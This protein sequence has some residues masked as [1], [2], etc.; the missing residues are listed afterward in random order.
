MSACSDELLKIV[1]VYM[2]SELD[3]DVK[4]FRVGSVYIKRFKDLDRSGCFV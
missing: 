2:E 1:Y 4:V 3:E